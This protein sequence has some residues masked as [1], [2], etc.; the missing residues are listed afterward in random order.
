MPDKQA[1]DR[2][3]LDK[4][5]ESSEAGALHTVDHFLYFPDRTAAVP[6]VDELRR[7]GFDIEE[8]VSADGRNWLVQAHHDIV[9]SENTIAAT[10]TLMEELAEQARGTYD[11]WGAAT[12]GKIPWWKQMWRRLTPR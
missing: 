6:V 2:L 10:R 4:L 12:R 9:P 5:F 1:L 11:G 8:T 7:R 3:T